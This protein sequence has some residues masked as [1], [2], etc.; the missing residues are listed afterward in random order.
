MMMCELY[1]ISGAS[2]CEDAL[3]EANTRPTNVH[4]QVFSH[5]EMDECKTSGLLVWAFKTILN[6][7]MEY[8]YILSIRTSK[9]KK[10]M[11]KV[12][13]LNT[14]M[15]CHNSNDRCAHISFVCGAFRSSNSITIIMAVMHVAY[16]CDVFS[17]SKT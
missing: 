17:L 12:L 8:S 7:S 4:F 5:L 15:Q 10:I 2:M 6:K 9:S 1:T 3:C 11:K 14:P 13:G 16:V